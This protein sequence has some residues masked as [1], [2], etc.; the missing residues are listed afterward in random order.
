MSN[1]PSTVRRYRDCPL[2]VAYGLGIDS[3]AMLVEFAKRDIRPDLILF[4]DRLPIRQTNYHHQE[5]PASPQPGVR[6]AAFT[7]KPKASIGT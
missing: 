6:P 4:A 1:S 3:T 7:A 5:S 2:V